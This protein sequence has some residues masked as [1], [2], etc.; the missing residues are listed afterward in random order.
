[1]QLNIY[2]LARLGV[3]H[4]D[5]VSDFV[6]IAASQ[7]EARRMASDDAGDE[8]AYT[9]VDP[10]DSSCVAIG[11]ALPDAVPGPVVRSFHAG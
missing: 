6:V 1:M 8:G 4:Y 2:H 7:D 10:A 9:W 11:T 5:E 3:T